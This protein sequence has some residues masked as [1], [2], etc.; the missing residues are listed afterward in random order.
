MEVL[1][2]RDS[3]DVERVI[4]SIKPHCEASWDAFVKLA[5][6]ESLEQ[7]VTLVKDVD[8]D[9]FVTD[10]VKNIVRET[11]ERIWVDPG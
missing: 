5:R 3:N 10:R 7:V 6:V 8:L 9:A 1:E 2:A 4:A 11:V